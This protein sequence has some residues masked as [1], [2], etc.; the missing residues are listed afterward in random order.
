MPTATTTDGAPPGSTIWVCSEVGRSNRALYNAAWKL[1]KCQQ[2]DQ[3]DCACSPRI[4]E[5]SQKYSSDWDTLID[6]A[7]QE[8]LLQVAEP[9]TD[10]PPPFGTV[11]SMWFVDQTDGLFCSDVM[12]DLSKHWGPTAY[13]VYGFKIPI[14]KD[15][16]VS[17]KKR[18]TFSKRSPPVNIDNYND[19]KFFLEYEP[20]DGDCLISQDD[21]DFCINAYTALVKSSCESLFFSADCACYPLVEQQIPVRDSCTKSCTAGGTNYGPVNDLMVPYATVDVGCAKFSWSVIDGAPPPP[22]PK[23]TLSPRTCHDVH[24]HYDVAPEE[25]DSIHDLECKDQPFK[26]TDPPIHWTPDGFSLPWMNYQVSWIEGCTT[27]TEQNMMYP[28]DDNKDINCGQLLSDDYYFCKFV[29]LFTASLGGY[30][31]LLFVNLT[32]VA[33]LETTY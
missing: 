24:D 19:Y 26:S 10:C 1:S 29:D 17:K 5:K 13:D 16:D 8:L 12:S 14:R 2:G 7:N 25:V 22:P 32:V 28:I 27:T 20:Q 11:P 31:I 33:W 30:P 18:S 6:Q 4:D 21:P 9:K 15:E 3:K 23:P